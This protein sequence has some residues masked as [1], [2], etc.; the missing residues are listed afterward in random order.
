[1]WFILVHYQTFQF[2]ALI[3]VDYHCGSS[4]GW[5]AMFYFTTWPTGSAWSPRL[6]L[7]GDM[8]AA[9]A[10]SLPRLQE[11]TQRG[12]YDAIIHVGDFGYNLDTV[13]TS[14]YNLDSVI[15]SPYNL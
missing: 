8:G 4:K 10:Q 1:M 13:S 9:N 5:S 6:A 3:F 12:M 14:L 2:S 11:D 7:Y 15:T